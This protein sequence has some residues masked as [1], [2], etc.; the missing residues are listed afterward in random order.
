MNTS[1]QDEKLVNVTAR[2]VEALA[3][4]FLVPADESSPDVGPASS[5]K[6]SFTGPACG[7]LTLSVSP[8][9][10]QALAG[11]MLGLDDSASEDSAQDALNELGNVICGNLLPAVF[12]TEPVFRVEAPVPI[13]DTD[14]LPAEAPVAEAMLHTD[15][16]QIRVRFYI[17]DQMTGQDG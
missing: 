6:V 3:L 2:T 10:A 1:T 14:P 5:V 12:G 7:S 16:G 15:E 9:V 8:R 4:M 17:T 11:N 13:S